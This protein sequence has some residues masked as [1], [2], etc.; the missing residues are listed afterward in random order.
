VQIA[1][2]HEHA[3]ACQLDIGLDDV[4]ARVDGQVERCKCVLGRVAKTAN[5]SGLIG[6]NQGYGSATVQGFS[7]L[8]ASASSA[9]FG[10]C[11]Q[12]SSTAQHSATDKREHRRQGVASTCSA[13]MIGHGSQRG[14]QGR[15]H[16]RASRHSASLAQFP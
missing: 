3:V 5:N 11:Q 13:P 9:P 6:S 8:E 7:I 14:H 4:S 16:S 12:A 15:N 2:E 10:D 1:K